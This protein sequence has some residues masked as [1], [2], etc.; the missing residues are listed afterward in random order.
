MSIRM[1]W[2]N[3]Q[4]ATAL[5]V[6]L[7]YFAKNDPGFR[8]EEVGMCGAGAELNRQTFHSGLLVGASPDGVLRHSN[9]TIEALE[10]KN[11]CPF[12]TTLYKTK[13]SKHRKRFSVSSLPRGVDINN[14]GV[15][16]HYVP[17]LQM[18]MLC[19]GP[20]CRSAVMVR[21]TARGGAL[22]L[23]MKRDDEWI[24]EMLYWLNRFQTDFVQANK[25]PPKDFFWNASNRSQRSRYRRFINKT[26]EVRK[27]NVEVIGAI[28]SRDIQRGDP[29]PLFLD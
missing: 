20:E 1:M 28:P 16:S 10:V 12:F 14:G 19:V 24:A 25:P 18:E 7:N 27:N 23:R 3:T 5:L 21:L 11:H 29:S 22:L 26:M 17:Q 15:F 4:E 6:A 13:K 9:G 2:G 8:L